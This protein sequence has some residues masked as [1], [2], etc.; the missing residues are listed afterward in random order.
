MTIDNLYLNSLEYLYET[1]P[2]YVKHLDLLPK[3]PSSGYYEKIFTAMEVLSGYVCAC[4]I[5]KIAAVNNAKVINVILNTH[6]YSP[7]LMI[8]FKSSIFVSNVIHE[9]REILG[10]TLRH[11]ETQHAKSIRVLKR[12]HATKETSLNM[13]SGESRKQCHKYL[14]LGILKENHHLWTEHR[15]WAHSFNSRMNTLKHRGPQTW[16]KT[17]NSW[18]PTTDFSS[19]ILSG[20]PTL[21]SKT[22]K[23]DMQSYI[24][25]N[26]LW[27][28]NKSPT[29]ARRRLLLLIAT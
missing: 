16:T 28:K 15:I 7:T 27:Q 20:T 22:K 18:V 23:I 29:S 1:A 14:P 11:A 25:T 4:Q 9:T 12:T 19:E 8:T 3:L 21:C 6:V 13:S 17:P 2:K 24:V 26:V 10:I 5:Y